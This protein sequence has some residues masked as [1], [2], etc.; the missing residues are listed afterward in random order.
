MHFLGMFAAQ[1][2]HQSSTSCVGPARLAF[3][4]G[5]SVIGLGT[6]LRQLQPVLVKPVQGVADRY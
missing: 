1:P 5:N 3:R 2:A 6:A 4:L